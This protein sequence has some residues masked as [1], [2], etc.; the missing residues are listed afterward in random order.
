[1][2]LP[3]I[4]NKGEEA[5]LLSRLRVFEVSIIARFLT[6]REK[7]TVCCLLN[8]SWFNSI[9]KN[10]FW[11]RLPDFPPQVSK[12]QKIDFLRQFENFGG[13]DLPKLEI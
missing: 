6:A 9:Y 1:M 13:L 8:R 5:A 4:P 10:Y 11:A 12:Y 3:N 7:L 2:A